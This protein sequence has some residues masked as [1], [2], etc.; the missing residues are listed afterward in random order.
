LQ[1]SFLTIRVSEQTQ[2]T[3]ALADVQSGIERGV[4]IR[5]SSVAAKN[6]GGRLITALLGVVLLVVGALALFPAEQAQAATAG[7]GLAASYYHDTSFKRRAFTRVDRQ[8]DFNWGYGSPSTRIERDTFAA[9]WRGYLV[10]PVTG[11]YTLS[12]RASDGARLWIDGQLRIA[13]WS[14]ASSARENS[15][16]VQLTQGRHRL[17][18]DYYE[19]TGAASARLSWAGPGFA[20][21]VVPASRLYLPTSVTPARCAD[22][23]DNDGDGHVDL[24]ADPGCE[25]TGDDSETDP[26][27]PD[28]PE[29]AWS[30]PATWGGTVPA[31]GSSVTIPAGKIVLLDRNVTLANL[32]VNGELR[33]SRRDIELTA[34]WVIVHGKLEI[35]TEAEPFTHRATIRLRDTQPNENVM[36]M[37]DKVLGVMG[38][39]A[40]LHGEARTGWTKLSATAPRGTD[41]LTLAEAPDWRPGDRIA[42]ASTDYARSQDEEATVTSVSGNVVTL[43]RTLEYPH[44]GTTQVFDGRTVDQR[45]EV[46]L[47]TRNV[48]I[49]G[50]STSSA[51]GF[52]AQVMVMNSGIARFDGVQLQR[53]GQ[54]GILRRYPI[55]FHMLGD[56]G[57]NSYLRNSS[58]HHSSNRC[59]TVHGTNQM[60]V[61]GNVCFDHAGHGFFLEDGAEHDNVIEGN[62]GMGTREPSAA[63]RLLASDTSPATFWITNPDNV[64]RNNVAAGSDG[65]GFWIA[66]PTHPT[67]L[68]STMYPT[69]TQALWPRRTALTEF[70]GNT[71]HSNAEDG[72]HFDRG[73]RPDGTVETA[74]HHA[75]ENPASTS[76]PTVVTTMSDYKAYKNR[77]HGAWLRGSH[78]RLVNATLSDNARGATF[79]SDESFL[80]NSLVVGETAN[81]GTPAQWEI[82]EGGVGRDGRSLPKPWDPAFPIRGFEF[83]DGRVGAQNTTFVNFQPYTTAS[84]QTRQQSALGYQLDNDFSLHP[85]NFAAGLTFVN[86]KRVY[87]KPPQVGHDGDISAVF[88]DTDGSVTGTAG[89]YVMTSNPFL[90]GSNCE[91]RADWGA[92][93]CN[94]DYAT[95]IVE[96][97]DGNPSAVK[98]VTLTRPDQ[99]VQTMMGSTDANATDA[100]T[101]VLTG[102]AYR[103]AFN[104]GTPARSKFIIYRGRDRWVR[105]SVPRAEGFRVLR[106]G[107]NVGQSGTWCYGAAASSAALDAAVRPSYWYDNGG[108]SDPSTG[109]LHLKLTSANAD[110]DELEV[111]P[112]S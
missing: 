3:I 66:L 105:V 71:A 61:A 55:H 62:L 106:Y 65:H 31:E 84:G 74:H 37:G 100:S 79:A 42:I 89:K 101:S 88:L 76:S 32:T 44:F 5:M 110:W 58:I 87:L 77:G 57:A 10:A 4:G 30:D 40:Q 34:D 33:F 93:V 22:G 26:P 20:K 25:T 24:A 85:R 38:G 45:A 29:E 36:N 23:L 43:D 21:Q 50:E 90:Y 27:P 8:I 63:N 97:N 108:D 15:V 59:V 18:L 51:G 47:L 67:G 56:A 14:A 96:S 78:H 86:S 104:G 35:G 17:G 52:G 41:R 75:R 54:Q 80:Q 83:Y 95:L 11:Q 107:C 16:T 13:R 72:L 82:N 109:T 111:V 99:Q 94:G 53:V 112:A 9:R 39:T 69:E 91:A 49:E 102:T 73:P 64:V 6:L 60:T 92:Q 19:N 70:S 28:G 1:R 81:R 68:F 48:T 98:P 103:V 46:A 7:Q 12:V 2:G